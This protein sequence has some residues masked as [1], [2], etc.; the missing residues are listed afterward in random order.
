MTASTSL[1]LGSEFYGI[2]AARRHYFDQF[3]MIAETDSGTIPD[4]RRT[5]EIALCGLE[6]PT[7]TTPSEHYSIHGTP[8]PQAHS[9][10]RGA[11]GLSRTPSVESMRTQHAATDDGTPKMLAVPLPH[12]DAPLLSKDLVDLRSSSANDA[13]LWAR[14]ANAQSDVDVFSTLALLAHTLPD[15]DVILSRWD[16]APL[17]L[18]PFSILALPQVLDLLSRSDCASEKSDDSGSTAKDSRHSGVDG[19]RDDYPIS[20]VD[21]IDGRSDSS[22]ETVYFDLDSDA[23]PPEGLDLGPE[24][25]M[26]AESLV[27]SPVESEVETQ[28][29]GFQVTVIPKRRRMTT[30]I[31][32]LFPQDI[33]MSSD[34]F[35]RL[36]YMAPLDAAET[37]LWLR[38]QRQLIHRPLIDFTPDPDEHTDDASSLPHPSI[39]SGEPKRRRR[40]TLR[41]LRNSFRSTKSKDSVDHHTDNPSSTAGSSHTRAKLKKRRATLPSMSV[42]DDGRASI[43]ST[44]HRLAG[45]LHG[46]IGSDGGSERERHHSLKSFRTDS[47]S[48]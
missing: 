4:S 31:P 1:S 21:D 16:E 23:E 36:S 35:Q 24:A 5:S 11:N 10:L 43:A 29:S 3:L 44:P 41:F 26:Q 17:Q 39:H 8:T 27:E 47:T 22:G 12:E 42:A 19:A 9:I 37:D 14:W 28:Y 45:W 34:D 33:L 13:S 38:A 6:V 20:L 48:Q 18:R 25:H 30:P 32:R 2:D 46:V 40:F 15:A 7:D